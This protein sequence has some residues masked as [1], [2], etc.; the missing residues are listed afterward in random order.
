M[1]TIFD[2]VNG[3]YDLELI[4][5]ISEDFPKRFKGN[6]DLLAKKF[7]GRYDTFDDV[8]NWSETEVKNCID[9]VKSLYER[10]NTLKKGI[11]TA[12][13]AW[14]TTD[15]WINNHQSKLRYWNT[16]LRYL[17]EEKEWS[18]DS[19]K[20]LA[21]ETTDIVNFLPNPYAI[22]QTSAT[23]GKTDYSLFCKKGL[24]YGDV[25][26]GKTG[27]M[28]CLASMYADAGCKFIFVLSGITNNLREQTQSRFIKELKIRNGGWVLLTPNENNDRVPANFN[29][30]DGLGSNVAIGFFK[31]NPAALNRLIQYCQQT[32]NAS[33]WDDKQV[34]I[35]DDECDQ[36]TPNVAGLPELDENGEP[37]FI[38]EETN[39]KYPHS[40]INGLIVQL[41]KYFPRVNYVG[42]SATP[43]ANVLNDI[44][45]KESIYP[46]D[47]IYALGKNPMYFGAEKIFKNDEDEN[48]KSLDVL[49]EINET[50]S[51][52]LRSLLDN[53][54][55]VLE[56]PDS[57]KQ[58]INY[59]LLAA[60][61]KKDRQLLVHSTMLIH[62][63]MKT[64]LH[65]EI[66]NIVSQYIINIK[67]NFD[68][69]CPILKQI[70]NEEKSKIQISDILELFP[71]EKKEYF[72][73]KTFDELKECLKDILEKIEIIV[74]NST[75]AT[76]NRLFY[77]E[78]N[79][80]DEC[81]FIIAVGGNTLS[82]GLTL[83]GLTVSYFVRSSQTYDTL[84]QMGRW[85]GY[86]PHYEDLIRIWMSDTLILDFEHLSK[87]INYFREEIEYNFGKLKK[88]KEFA[89]RIFTHSHLNVARAAAI[90]RANY[91]HF[92]YEGS[93]SESSYLYT[94]NKDILDQNIKAAGN[95]F[96]SIKDKKEEYHNAFFYRDCTSKTVLDFIDNYTFNPQ[97]EDCNKE[98]LK[99]YIRISNEKGLLNNWIIVL[100]Q[101][102]KGDT[103]K[104]T[105]DIKVN[106]ITRSCRKTE[107]EG[108][109]YVRIHEPR[110]FKIDTPDDIWKS[111]AGS[112]SL[113]QQI[114]DREKYYKSINQKTPGLMLVYP[115]DG[116]NAPS[117]VDGV[118]KHKI[119]ALSAIIGLM[120]VFPSTTD[121]DLKESVS[122][123]LYPEN[124]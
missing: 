5:E 43:F 101:A 97:N 111:K 91:G 95:L 6:W 37:L 73:I 94:A 64:E 86:R 99:E 16:Y 102:Q 10:L 38:D 93:Y 81:R 35:I 23:T 88:P 42:Y 75:I 15:D 12:N 113:G 8:E 14:F 17:I 122:I 98:Y 29:F 71:S 70:W 78:P 53:E 107:Y 49:R 54:E 57:L 1:A 32:T 48:S 18:D 76:E 85:F 118:L 108:T 58:A 77:K 87:V 39:E 33:F 74:D 67:N 61:T 100:K 40:R 28:E 82:R 27:S 106:M 4:K 34:L 79:N 115:I 3:Q 11:S 22:P 47:F 65:K 124:K 72:T 84:L 60:A 66:S 90:Q 114:S 55:C 68:D 116:E 25:Q 36:Y 56:C 119:S 83:E 41:I 50:E 52:Y 62:I 9:F 92:T 109:C 96:E 63:N 59:F 19:L 2:F 112:A 104:L 46:E 110:D 24:V 89:P 44:P 51:H 117:S 120:F 69:Y 105:E 20:K 13:P 26:A 45:G 123:K 103:L 121:L 31:K 80:L 30:V 21:A 7:I